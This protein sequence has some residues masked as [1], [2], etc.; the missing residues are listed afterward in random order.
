MK[1]GTKVYAIRPGT[2]SVQA[3]K[4]AIAGLDHAFLH[5]PKQWHD[6]PEGEVFRVPLHHIFRTKAEGDAYINATNV[7][8]GD[9]VAVADYNSYRKGLV[10]RTTDKTFEMLLGSEKDIQHNRGKMKSSHRKSSA[11]VLV[12]AEKAAK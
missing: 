9:Y 11:I 6:E 3:Y 4:L 1:K 7:Q 10:V 2:N 12:K 8:V 5:M